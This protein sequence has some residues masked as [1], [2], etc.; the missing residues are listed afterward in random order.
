MLKRKKYKFSKENIFKKLRLNVDVVTAIRGSKWD[1]T[2]R[3][4]IDF[5]T[6]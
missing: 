5:A 6:F 2:Q 3:R 4:P 1:P